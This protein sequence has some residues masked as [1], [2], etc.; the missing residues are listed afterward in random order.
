MVGALNHMVRERCQDYQYVGFMGDDH[1]PRT[2]RWDEILCQALEQQQGGVAYGDDKLQG[3][4]LPTAVVMDTAITAVLGYMAPPA[5]KHLYVDNVWRDWGTELGLLCYRP[6]VVIEHMHPGAGKADWDARYAQTGS[7]D[8]NNQDFKAY[9]KYLKYQLSEDLGRLKDHYGRVS[10]LPSGHGASAYNAGVVRDA[11]T[12]TA[13]G[14]AG[15][16]FSPA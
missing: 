4:A 16:P 11:R 14:G 1:L 3:E 9:E 6:D 15:S 7:A 13:L 5:L 12:S 10:T 2:P 8:V